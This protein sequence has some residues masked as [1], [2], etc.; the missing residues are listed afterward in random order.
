[1]KIDLQSLLRKSMG[2][3]I[4]AVPCSVDLEALLDFNDLN[5]I[6][7]DVQG[8]FAQRRQVVILWSVSDVQFVRNDL[9][10]ELAWNVLRE[11]SRRHT[12]EQGLNRSLILQV[13]E[14]LYPRSIIQPIIDKE[15]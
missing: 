13:A 8:L 4:T 14:Q 7:V 1:M 5:H 2:N 10:D 6:N 12:R 9:S 3:S 11:C 15:S